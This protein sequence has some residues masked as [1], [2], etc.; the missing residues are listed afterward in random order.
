MRKRMVWPRGR[1]A[2][3][4]LSL[5]W[6]WVFP[7]AAES[8]PSS[9][10]S[11]RDAATVGVDEA[12]DVL[13]QIDAGR[14][15]LVVGGPF[16]SDR[17]VSLGAKV[18]TLGEVEAHLA[19][20]PMHHEAF[21]PKAGWRVR[22]WTHA[23]GP[24]TAK[25]GHLEPTDAGGCRFVTGGP[26]AQWD[27]HYLNV[28]PYGAGDDLLLMEVRSAYPNAQMSVELVDQAN[29]RWFATVEIGTDWKK[30]ALRT[31]DFVR[32][33]RPVASLNP[34]TIRRLG[35]GVSEQFT[36]RMAKRL[37]SFEI[38]CLGSA[39]NPLPPGALDL[40]D[41]FPKTTVEGLWPAY[42]VWEKNGNLA[43]YDRHDG[44]GYGR[45]N[46][47]RQKYLGNEHEMILL[48]RRAG[49][50]ERCVAFFGYTTRERLEAPEVQARL[51][52][53]RELLETGALLFEGGSDQ[54]TYFPGETAKIGASWRGQPRKIAFEIRTRGGASVLTREFADEALKNG[55]VE[56]AWPIPTAPE[57]TVWHV[58][59]TLDAGADRIA[60][61]FARAKTLPDPPADFITVRDGDFWLKG[62]KWYPACINFWPLYVCAAER[63]DDWSVWQR[64]GHYAPNLVRKDLE[65]FKRLGGNAISI[66][67]NG[68]G[69]GR[70]VRDLYRIC[71]ELGLYVN[72]ALESAS[73]FDRSPKQR[74]ALKAYFAET[75]AAN[76]ATVFAYDTVWEPGNHVFRS[77]DRWNADWHA[78]AVEQFGSIERAVKS[79]GYDPGRDAQ[80]HLTSPPQ[81]AFTGSSEPA[82][83]RK[84]MASYR[85]FM[86][87]LTSRK[88][89]VLRREL[90]ALAPHQLQSFRQ[91]NTLPHDFALT[92]PMRHID[93]VMPEGYSF[94][95]TD[96][97]EVA[98]GWITR[99]IDAYS[100]RKPILWS[101][102]G[103]NAWDRKRQ[104]IDPAVVRA[105]AG[106]TERF[107]RAGLAAGA[108]GFSPWWFP[109][110]Y[111]VDERSD[112][113]YMGPDGTPRA[114]L[115]TFAAWVPAMLKERT[116]PCD[117][118]RHVFDRDANPG[119][120]YAAAFVTRLSAEA[121][122]IAG[123]ELTSATAPSV[124]LGDVPLEGE[125]P[126]KYLD[127]DFD[128]FETALGADGVLAVRAQ[129]GNPGP[130]TWKAGVS[131]T[132]GV[133]LVAYDAASG[134]MLAAA[135]LV[136]DVP[137]L[138][139][140]DAWVLEVPTNAAQRIAFR[141][142]AKDRFR[143]GEKRTWTSLVRAR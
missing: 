46:I 60:H 28:S 3:L 137:R 140:T 45:G 38:R 44:A 19:N 75:D 81:A 8:R 54:F 74:S 20:L 21:G 99:Y 83:W 111:R 7:S 94:S 141:L 69:C 1:T 122:A 97:D 40:P 84:V 90:A 106:Y 11:V 126:L 102:F 120:Y 133:S 42:K 124:A 61:D 23:P 51:A 37:S 56:F 103:R 47:W 132:G 53:T 108:N 68:W 125:M 110:G 4:M 121:M 112:Y 100:G 31:S 16:M 49:R 138:G 32:N 10:L 78:W 12:R 88:W 13:A 25:G 129:L 24:S 136:R 130:A 107:Y 30:I 139:T 118:P 95:D 92:G 66:Q 117:P 52:M 64:D 62:R 63:A 87:N 65:S 142:E 71:R 17:K 80:G 109:G 22:D 43:F 73:P 119:G 26:L 104:G 79:W 9:V 33:G 55:K 70:N 6:V 27:I 72:Q 76:D 134:R 135:P 113:G 34:A 91:G 5:L 82:K 123:T 67:Y 86:D 18:L 98:I 143:F 131:G 101:E 35:I 57:G 105:C 39:K 115:K 2:F 127:A 50:P 116:K 15:A 77:R 128:V 89:A 14:P 36:A 41:D 93:F 59:V 96:A 58:S 114:P 85:R 29:L 48:E